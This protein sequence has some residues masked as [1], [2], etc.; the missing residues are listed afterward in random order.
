[1][2]GDVVDDFTLKDQDGKEFNLF[3]N[4]DKK[5]LLV[6][7]PKD[8]SP[9]CTRQLLNYNRF[10]SEFEKLN[11]SVIGINTGSCKSHQNFCNSIGDSI[12]LLCDE[13][14]SVSKM[15]SA[16]NIFGINK[17][18]LILI[19]TD[20]RIIFE[21]ST[22]PTQYIDAEKIIRMIREG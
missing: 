22:F 15:F 16:I 18:K 19:G 8:D 13:T 17:R 20:K 10:E 14:K 1:M 9:V 4:L 6:F 11:I 21:K 7:Y 5:V 2:I 3:R 12:R